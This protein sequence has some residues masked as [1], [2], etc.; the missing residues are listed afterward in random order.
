M[1]RSFTSVVESK[2]KARSRN[3][4]IVTEE[5][6]LNLCANHPLGDENGRK[7]KKHIVAEKI[8]LVEMAWHGSF[9]HLSLAEN[10]LGKWLLK[11]VKTS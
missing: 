1:I 5:I 8:R 2:E 4:K 10:D 11:E 7:E 6:M 3:I 9:S